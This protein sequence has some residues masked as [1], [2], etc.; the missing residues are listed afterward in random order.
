LPEIV[1][2]KIFLSAYLGADPDCRVQDEHL[3]KNLQSL[4]FFVKYG[5]Y[6]D[7]FFISQTSRMNRGPWPL[8]PLAPTA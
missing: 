7:F 5:G 1:V 6:G 3:Q 4:N 8:Q 2:T